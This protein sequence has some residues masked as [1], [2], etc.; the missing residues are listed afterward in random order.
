MT[1]RGH[2]AQGTLGNVLGTLPKVPY[3]RSCILGHLR[4]AQRSYSPL[5]TDGTHPE[6]PIW[7]PSLGPHSG[8]PRGAQLGYIWVNQLALGPGPHVAPGPKAHSTLV[9]CEPSQ[10]L[11]TA[12]V[13][14]L[15][16]TTSVWAATMPIHGSGVL[17]RRCST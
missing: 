3:N 1:T 13:Q 2:S 5:N 10:V 17:H 4:M 6:W 16:T 9:Y 14:C 15:A 11:Y 7:A 12:G 8:V